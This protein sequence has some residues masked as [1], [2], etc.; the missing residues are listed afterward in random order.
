MSF[1]E[2]VLETLQDIAHSN[3]LRAERM[4]RQNLREA[5][6]HYDEFTPEQRESYHYNEEVLEELH[7]RNEERKEYLKERDREKRE[8]EDEDDDDYWDVDDE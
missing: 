1:L 8:Q 2:K 4:A 6:K 5:S 3:S 7:E